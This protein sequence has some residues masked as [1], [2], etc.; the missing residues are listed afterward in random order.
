MDPGFQSV[1][2][3]TFAGFNA[4]LTAAFIKSK[5]HLRERSSLVLERPGNG[6]CSKPSFCRQHGAH[7]IWKQLTLYGVPA[8]SSMSYLSLL[9]PPAFMYLGLLGF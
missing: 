8:S 5:Q 3:L 6:W 9:L 1:I 7:Y 2:K 4:L